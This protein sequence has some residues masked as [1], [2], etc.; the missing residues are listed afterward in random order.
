MISIIRATTV[1]LFSLLLVSA[2]IVPV[3]GICLCAGADDALSS[4][5]CDRSLG[6]DACSCGGQ[7]GDCCSADD[8]AS[9]GNCQCDKVD[10]DSTDLAAPNKVVAAPTDDVNVNALTARLVIV[11][12]SPFHYAQPAGSFARTG[13]ALSKLLCRWLT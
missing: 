9:C 7:A 11:T 3:A 5:G 10:G 6:L 2:P 13:P 1:G 4:C 12:P 8:V